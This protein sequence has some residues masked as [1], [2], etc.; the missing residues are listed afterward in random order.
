MGTR[1]GEGYNVGEYWRIAHSHALGYFQISTSAKICDD[2]MLSH[3]ERIPH[4]SPMDVHLTL[5][6]ATRRV[7][8][9]RA[10]LF[11]TASVRGY[12]MHDARATK[13]TNDNF[14]I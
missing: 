14:E 10:R 8:L 11:Y 6:L 13:D 5:V 9:N 3:A 2:F 1:G 7:T 4:T 12:Q